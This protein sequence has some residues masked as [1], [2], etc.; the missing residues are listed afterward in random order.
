MPIVA[1]EA[2]EYDEREIEERKKTVSFAPGGLP[3]FSVRSI[4]LGYAVTRST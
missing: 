3:S 4:L 1:V 2:I